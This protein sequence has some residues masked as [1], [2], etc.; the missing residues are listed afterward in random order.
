MAEVADNTLIDGRYR[1]TSR[2]GS[3]GMADVYAAEDTH[4]GR[5][6]AIK[7]LYRRFAQDDEFVERFRREAKSAAGLQHPNVVNVF[8]RGEHDGTYYIAMEHLRGRTLKEI[9]SSESPLDET[10]AIDLAIQILRAA[11]FAHRRG[12]IHRDFK[13]HNVIVDD[14][15]GAKVTDFG[16]ARAGASEM[17]ETGSIMGTAQYL[18]PEQAQGHGVT[19][20]SD[21]YSIAVILYELLAGQVPFDGES[22][23][24]VALKHLND[25]PPPLSA[26]RAGVHPGLEGVVMRGLAKH[27]EQRFADADELIAV[28]E[29]V[30]EQIQAGEGYGGQTAMFPA[31]META[32]S[33]LP[34][35][36]RRRRRW[37]YVAL[38]LVGLALIAAAVYAITRPEEVAVPDVVGGTL[39]EAATRLEGEGFEVEAQR[40]QDQAP[41]DEVIRQDPRG[42][43][44]ADEGSQVTLT[45]SNGPGQARVPS[46]E[47]RP[48][49]EAVE[50]LNDKGFDVTVD[51]E[52]SDD[53]DDGIAIR[54][55]P[56][57]GE[58]ADRGERI[59]LF[60]STGP[61]SVSVP[62]VVGSSERSAESRLERAGLLVDV[63]EEAS[64]SD[65]GTVI[66]QAPGP[67]AEVDS[68]TRV[69]IVVSTGREEVEVPS[70]LGQ[71]LREARA[72]LRDAGFEVDAD[73]RA[74]DSPA[75]DGV[76][77][78][79]RPGGGSE[80]RRGDTVTIFV[81]R[82]EEPEPPPTP[83]PP[84]DAG[85]P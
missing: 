78:D 13:P 26:L 36:R 19:A 2:I 61:E 74:V 41:V 60:V 66:R 22:A 58:L 25:A 10:R 65:E 57:G 15:D 85:T 30:R 20:Q 54:T 37:P 49:G 56:E 44:K 46:V 71:S 7:V 80:R 64:G 32:E 12:V 24:S 62:D 39:L 14:A 63:E 11:G 45:V 28:L 33:A 1:I 55:V 6:V 3:G 47:G 29:D 72:T 84:P 82:F 4:L 5:D 53:F 35:E 83:P 52:A 8:D 9:V 27:P 73:E 77:V 79:Q 34:E 31:P 81:G 51:G 38:G 42:G 67:G 40:V 17:T 50:E 76:V 16:I 18:S 70:V 43:A 59:R 75:E 23:V 69:T 68:G 21:L 48:R